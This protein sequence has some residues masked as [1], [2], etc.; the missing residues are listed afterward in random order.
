MQPIRAIVTGASSGIG[1]EIA[2]ELARRVAAESPAAESPAEQS[3]IVVHYRSNLEGARETVRQIHRFGIQTHLVASD[4]RDADDRR[5]LVRQAWDFLETP[6][7]WIN[8]AGADVLTGDAKDGSFE[9]KLRLLM[10]TDVLGTIELTR[11]VVQRWSSAS[12]LPAQPPSVTMIGWDQAPDGMEGDAGQMFGPVKA[13]VMAFA[14]SLAQDLAPRIR[15]NTVA[16]GWIRTAWGESTDAYWDR[17]AREQSLMRRWGTPQDVAAAVCY[18]ADPAN[19]FC[20]G[21]TLVVNGGF[22]RTHR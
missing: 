18:V 10:E 4:I 20:T 7:T 9:N 21:Q 2:V 5:E 22:D 15:V 19:S 3:R 6:T 11:A 12:D 1:R 14:N 17:R 16:P 8:N 13:A